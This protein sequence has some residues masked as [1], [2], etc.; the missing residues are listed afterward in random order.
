MT[1]QDPLPDLDLSDLP[2]ADADLT[3]QNWFD[4]GNILADLGLHEEA[5]TSYEKD[6]EIKPDDE[7]TKK[8]RRIALR[9][10]NSSL[11]RVKTW[12]RRWFMGNRPI[13]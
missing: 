3:G 13:R 10:L 5:I 8:N 9:K 12:L 4:K 2:D 11:N 7:L 6:L 1:Q